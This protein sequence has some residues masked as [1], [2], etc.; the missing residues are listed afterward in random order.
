MLKKALFILTSI[1][2]GFLLVTNGYYICFYNVFQKLTLEAVEN[3]DYKEAG[4]Y[5]AYSFDYDNAIY[6]ETLED[7]THIDI[8]PALNIY[9]RDAKKDDTTVQYSTIE[10]SIQFALFN[11]PSEFALADKTVS[12]G[13]TAVKGGVK[14]EFGD[15]SV[16]FAFMPSDLESYY[17]YAAYYNFMPFT[18][19]YV[20][21]VSKMT[22]AGIDLNAVPTIQILDGDNDSVYTV[23]CETALFDTDFHNA[24]YDTVTQYNELSKK[25][26]LE[27]TT[28]EELTTLVETINKT[29]DDN[30]FVKQHS[31]EIVTKSNA[32]Y[33]RLGLM[34]GAFLVLDFLIGFLLFRKKKPTKFVP[35]KPMMSKP[36]SNGPKLNYQ[37]EQFS[38]KDFIDAEETVTEEVVEETNE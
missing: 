33:I 27:G 13:E 20:D 25:D 34:L 31:V 24:Y 30:G 19:H 1:L 14:L 22:E 35:R 28:S 38:R 16:F 18:I 5:Y 29:T 6:S 11:L 32:F 23:V 15:K 7:G 9:A 10:S 8:Y 3:N 37:P 4:K 36:V 2:I 12:E 26:A 21:Y 17:S